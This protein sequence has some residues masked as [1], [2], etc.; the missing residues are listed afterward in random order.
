MKG[1]AQPGLAGRREALSLLATLPWL[2]AG[3]ATTSRTEVSAPTVPADRINHWSGRFA[4]TLTEPGAE[5]REERASGRFLLHEQAGITEL[6][7]L[8]PLGQT[9]ATASLGNG[10]ASLTTTDGERYEADSAEALTE[11]VFGWR[12]PIGNLP[13]WLRGRLAGT[14]STIDGVVDAVEHGWAIRLDSWRDTGPGR[15]DLDWP[16]APRPGVRRVKLRLIVDQ[17][18]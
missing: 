7:L 14:S 17:A 10:R 5:I 8:S 2:A 16:A 9:I 1:P 11:R 3:C 4:V 6:E 15:L 13:R 18:S 12:I